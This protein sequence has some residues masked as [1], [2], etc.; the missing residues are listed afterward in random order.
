MA[1]ALVEPLAAHDRL[2]GCEHTTGTRPR[3]KSASDRHCDCDASAGPLKSKP[4]LK[5]SASGRRLRR[6]PGDQ[7]AARRGTRLAQAWTDQTDETLGPT[8][9][10]LV[11]SRPARTLD[12][13]GL[14]FGIR[15]WFYEPGALGRSDWGAARRG[16]GAQ[17]A[18]RKN[19]GRRP[20]RTVTPREGSSGP[21][22]E[23][24]FCLPLAGRESATF[25]LWD[26]LGGD[27]TEGDRPR[28]RRSRLATAARRP[29]GCRRR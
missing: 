17:A 1:S 5:P 21:V 15:P 9:R 7:T 22:G 23:F 2:T 11:M 6:A 18:G 26:T 24:V 29:G 14:S 12:P 8:A 16:P 20:H 10:R 3:A 13:P 4:L 19:E 28:G 25:K 27:G